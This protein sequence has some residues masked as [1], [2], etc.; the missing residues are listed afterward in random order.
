VV[1]E[2][3]FL[4]AR[5]Q[6]QPNHQDL[7]QG[8]RSDSDIMT[9]PQSDPTTKWSES[10]VDFGPQ[11]QGPVTSASKKFRKVAAAIVAYLPQSIASQSYINNPKSLAS[12]TLKLNGVAPC[13]IDVPLTLV[14]IVTRQAGDM[15]RFGTV[16]VHRA[17][18]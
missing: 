4:A 17:P 8:S 9:V 14:P 18:E 3:P 12:A 1:H 7:S 16:E 15:P 2:K 10:N 11:P 5:Q 13:D 6:S